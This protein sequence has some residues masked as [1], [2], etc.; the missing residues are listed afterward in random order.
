MLKLFA[1]GNLTRDP[2]LRST[3][4]GTPV[5]TFTV[6]CNRRQRGAQA[7]QKDADYIRVTVWRK[8]AESCRQYLSKGKKVAVV[9]TFQQEEYT[10]RNGVTRQ[11]IDVQAEDVEFLSPKNEFA[12]DT[13]GALDAKQNAQSGYTQVADDDDL[14]F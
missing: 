13:V 5:C 9:G 4:D 10:D 11:Y 6:A 12:P 3:K 8:T 7:G 1:V 14:P 2:E